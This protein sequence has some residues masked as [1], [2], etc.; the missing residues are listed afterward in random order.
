MVKK[1]KSIEYWFPFLLTFKFKYQIFG[2]VLCSFVHTPP[3]Q[4]KAR[5]A[6]LGRKEYSPSRKFRV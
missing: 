6:L 1:N 3:L 4:L 2:L 5:K